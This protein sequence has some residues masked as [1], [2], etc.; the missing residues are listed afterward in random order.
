MGAGRRHVDIDAAGERHFR[1]AIL[2]R[3]TSLPR[4]VRRH[5]HQHLDAVADGEDRLVGLMEVADHRLH[6]LVDA[7]V[8]GAAAAGD[9]DGVIVGRIDLG[10]VLVS[11]KLWPS[12]SV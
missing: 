8:F 1:L 5:R 7:D 9:V 6:A 4:I 11:V 2:E 12:F 10:E 3:A